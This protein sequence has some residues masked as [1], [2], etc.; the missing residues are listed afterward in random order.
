M[1][2]E[3]REIRDGVVLSRF[4]QALLDNIPSHS[5]GSVDLQKNAFTN[6][7]FTYRD[8]HIQFIIKRSGNGEEFSHYELI[9]ADN[10]DDG[11]MKRM[12]VL[13][14]ERLD[15]E[16]VEMDC[17]GMR[18]NVIIDLNYGGRRWE[19]GELNGKPFGFGREYSEDGNLVYEGFVF[20]GK[21]V[22]FGKEWNDNSNNNILDYEGGYCI[23]KRWGKGKSYDLNGNVDFEGEWMNN[24]VIDENEKDLMNDLV[25]PITIEIMV[26]GNE[27]L[28]EDN[29]TTLYFS[30]L[31]IRLKRVK[32]GNQCFKHVREF[33]I[34]GLPCIKSVWISN[35]SFRR[36]IEK[37][38]DGLCRI[39]NCPN[40]RHIWI[41]RDSFCDFQSFELSNINSLQSIDIM[42]LCFQYSNKFVLHDFP[43][44]ENVLIGHYSFRSDLNSITNGLCRITNCPNLRQLKIN[45][46]SFEY[47]KSFVLYNVDSLQSI[48][49]GFQ[50]FFYA[51]FSLKGE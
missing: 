41:G 33:V 38:D 45:D 46:S 10:S 40:L 1:N 4:L 6:T 29:I 15:S 19:G 13:T 48:W 11:N 43:N 42:D 21:R 2:L 50:C 34:D 51:D 27:L 8:Y 37:R 24:H 44:L 30:S 25:V 32:I 7:S 22:C 31:L 9:V 3:E 17:S 16:L 26:L 35:D 39:T 49:F 20:E 47:F 36:S 23:D 18:E 28:N 14:A 5:I 12:A